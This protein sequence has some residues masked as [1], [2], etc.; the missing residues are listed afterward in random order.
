M[1]RKGTVLRASQVYVL[2]KNRHEK[3]LKLND[4]EPKEN[5]EY[6]EKG[7]SVGRAKYTL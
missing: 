2:W 4:E 7:L 6:V 3:T 5:F 1:E